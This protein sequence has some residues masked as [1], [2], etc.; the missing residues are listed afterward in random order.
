MTAEQELEKIVA[1]EK[2]A[3]KI[4]ALLATEDDL[5]VQFHAVTIVYNDIAE[6]VRLQRPELSGTDA[7]T[8]H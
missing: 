8:S 5:D 1:A 6:V 7:A 4:E 2:L 3:E